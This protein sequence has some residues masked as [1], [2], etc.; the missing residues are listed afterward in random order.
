MA[1]S[2]NNLI[3]PFFSGIAYNSLTG[4][5]HDVS[6]ITNRC[7]GHKLDDHA[8][9]SSKG[10]KKM[11]ATY[12]YSHLKGAV[13]FHSA[14]LFVSDVSWS[15]APRRN[16]N[17]EI[18]LCISGT[19]YLEVDNTAY[20]LKENEFLF[21]PANTSFK[22]NKPS[23][24]GLSF[25]WF[26]FYLPQGKETVSDPFVRKSSTPEI[27]LPLYSSEMN[28]CKTIILLNQLIA[29]MKSSQTNNGFLDYLVTAILLELSEE[30]RSVYEDTEEREPH[31]RFL[32]Y[33]KEWIRM[34]SNHPLTIE[35]IANHFGYNK[36]YLSHTFSKNTGTTISQF[37]L[38][39]RMEK[40]KSLL[41]NTNDTVTKV[42]A[43]CGFKD[44][45][46]F[47][48]VFKQTENMTPTAFRSALR[49]IKLN[50][51]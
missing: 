29:S 30:A 9:I 7:G 1:N 4:F 18:I 26:H 20:E 14:G 47:M 2:L 32:H 34:N 22:G 41:L 15:H 42:A 17:E 38:Q 51:T 28:L 50:N 3:P 33:V 19:L 13:P 10:G 25:Y 11:P 12:I 44:E 31:N 48:R 6:R 49:H 27:Y 37:I 21:I 23:E 45:K 43:D 5:V 36:A 8:T 39:V 24:K 35:E 40:A 16:P 46:Y